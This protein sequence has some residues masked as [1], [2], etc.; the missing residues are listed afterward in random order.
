MNIGMVIVTLL[1]TKGLP[2]AEELVIG[3]KTSCRL[4]LDIKGL[5][6]GPSSIGVILML[7]DVYSLLWHNVE[8]DFTL[9]L[10]F[11]KIFTIANA[12]PGVI[13][14]YFDY[15]LTTVKQDFCHS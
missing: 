10:P 13:Q 14:G 15:A 12:T 8:H 7:P 4:L 2:N 5:Q 3:D 6:G 1:H 9:P 11:D